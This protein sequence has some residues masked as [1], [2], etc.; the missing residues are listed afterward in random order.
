MIIWSPRNILLGPFPPAAVP[1]VHINRFGVIPKSGQAGK[2]RLIVD[3]SHP[4]GKHVNGGVDPHLCVL[5]Y[6]KVDQQ[7]V[8]DGPRCRVG[9][10]GCKQCISECASTP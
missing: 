8:R 4:K 7:V 5:S 6:V 9:K 1:H 2:W 10:V 3:L